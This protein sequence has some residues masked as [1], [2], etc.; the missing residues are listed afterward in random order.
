MLTARPALFVGNSDPRRILPIDDFYLAALRRTGARIVQPYYLGA[1]PAV[2]DRDLF[3][4]GHIIAEMCRLAGLH[5]RISLRP[6]F[7][8]TDAE[9]AAGAL[10]PRQI[11]LHS[12]GAAAALPYANKEWGPHNFAAVARLLSP[13]FH[14]V[15]IGSASDPALPVD[16][17]L[18]GKTSLRESAAILAHSLTFVGLEGFLAHLARSVECPAV[19]VFGGR[20]RPAT[21]GYSANRNLTTAVSCSPCG[22]R[23]TCDH[24]REC[25][26]LILP[27]TVAEAARQL[28]GAPRAPLAVDTALVA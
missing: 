1:D 25:M 18:R 27:T 9:R 20:S 8:L 26:T 28:A 22:L 7:F 13:D 17:D 2:A 11:A 12:T 23:A 24:A 10:H 5:G 6:Y 3:P 16:T 4:P 21:F 19:V 14:L 15:Q